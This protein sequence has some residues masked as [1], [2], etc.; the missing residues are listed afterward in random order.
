MSDDYSHYTWTF[1]LR[2]KFNATVTIQ[3]FHAYILNQFH[4]S[5]QFIQCDNGGEFINNTLRSFLLDRGIVFRLSCPYTSSQ[6]GKAERSI[7]TINDIVRTLLLQAHMPPSYWVEALNTATYLLNQRPSKPINFITP[8]Q[9]LFNQSPDYSHLRVFGCLWYPNLLPTIPHKLA[10]GSCRCVFLGY[11]P[12]HKGYRCLDLDS[13]KIII[14]RHVTFDETNFP[15]ALQQAAVTAPTLDPSA[16][17]LD[18]LPAPPP[19]TSFPSNESVHPPHPASLPPR[20]MCRPINTHPQL[21][22]LLRLHVAFC[23]AHHTRFCSAHTTPST[24]L[25]ALNQFS[26]TSYANPCQIR[27]F[28]T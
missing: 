19:A 4:L 21:R 28:C 8:Y 1:P 10:P 2:N 24:Q 27:N 13:R 25:H 26:S 12:E 3:N 23:Y 7:R 9:T 5:I 22:V 20:R 16:S 14:S 15:F 17:S 11:S 18:Q 6:N